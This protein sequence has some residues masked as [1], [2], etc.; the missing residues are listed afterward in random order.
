MKGIYCCFYLRRSSYLYILQGV[1]FYFAKKKFYCCY[2][3][4]SLKT[5]EFRWKSWKSPRT[6]MEKVLKSPGIWIFFF[7]WEPCIF[8]A[9]KLTQIYCINMNISFLENW[10][11]LNQKLVP[12]L[13]LTYQAGKSSLTIWQNMK[14]SGIQ[15]FQF[16]N[17]I[18]NWQKFGSTA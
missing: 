7:W 17:S 10:E 13:L 3:Y 6:L 2:S 8:P 5:L 4:K 14:V 11:F 15:K 9:L 16:S 18:V 1:C 12:P